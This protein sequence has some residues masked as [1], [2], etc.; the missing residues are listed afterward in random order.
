VLNELDSEHPFIRFSVQRSEAKDKAKQLLLNMH[1]L[2]GFFTRPLKAFSDDF[3]MKDQD[4]FGLIKFQIR[5]PVLRSEQSS[6][7]SSHLQYDENQ[8][9]VDFFEQLPLGETEDSNILK[10][11]LIF[12]LNDEKMIFGDSEEI[13]E[14]SS[15]FSKGP[16]TKRYDVSCDNTAIYREEYYE[17]FVGRAGVHHAYF[18][19][20]ILPPAFKSSLTNEEL[21]QFHRPHSDFLTLGQTFSIRI[22]SQSRISKVEEL[23]AKG[24]K[25]IPKKEKELSARDGSLIMLEYIE[26]RPPVLI[27]LG[28]A[29]EFLIYYRK[30]KPDDDY[31]PNVSF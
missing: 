7:L 21:K 25:H 6:F 22:P 5:R 24:K 29:S 31:V 10:T 26:E 1:P 23:L 19:R 20:D 8:E 17:G 3:H 4:Q 30:C 9:L 14:V 12:D 27:N 13:A 16:P 28:M 18:A 2:S 11:S 15:G